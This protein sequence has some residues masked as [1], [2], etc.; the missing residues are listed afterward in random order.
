VFSGKKKSKEQ[1]RELQELNIGPN[2]FVEVPLHDN[3]P[4]I[5]DFHALVGFTPFRPS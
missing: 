3:H 5:V 1:L 2:A 4:P